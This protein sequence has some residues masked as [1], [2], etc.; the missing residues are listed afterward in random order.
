LV[1]LKK[2]AITTCSFL[3]TTFLLKRFGSLLACL[4]FCSTTLL[5]ANL[6][7]ALGK[8]TIASSIEGANV[9]ATNATDGDHATRWSS[10]FTDAQ[11]IY[12]D[13]GTVQAIDRVR[14]T[15]ETAY[16]KN[17]RLE[18]SD[19]AS[20][21]TTVKTVVDN[22]P[23]NSNN[24]FVNEY[25]RLNATGRYVRIYGTTRATGYGY[26]LFEFEVFNYSNPTMTLASGKPATASNTQDTFTPSRAFDGDSTTRW[27]TTNTTNQWLAV[28]LRGTGTISRV[29]LNWERAWGI[30]YLVQVSDDASTWTTVATVTNNQ[31]YY[32]ELSMPK[33]TRGRYVRLYGQ[34]GGQNAGGFSLWEF[35][36]YGSLTPLASIAPLPVTLTSFSAAG[37]GTGV[38]VRWA[39]ASEQHNAGF[40]VQR[41]ANG[42]DFTS[43]AFVAG[44]GA[45]QAARTYEY[46]DAAPLPTTGYYRLKQLDTDGTVAYS[47]V[48][49][50]Q[51]AAATALSPLS[52]Y[53]NPATDRATLAWESAA[54]SA[55]RWY[56][57]S[58]TGQVV[59]SEALTTQ[60]GPNTLALD[61]QAYPSGR[62][63]LT[64][65]VAG[66]A[67]R[68]ALVQK[69]E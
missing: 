9:A 11:Y 22:Q 58:L 24:L 20:T 62:Y 31:A 51:A 1:I 40:E 30:D 64:L 3:M 65:E 42:V 29:C 5:A 44:A 26:S 59:H 54:A 10:A 36:V 57:T 23:L 21:W 67:L 7:L 14:L 39:T 53:P 60:V 13:L 61:L 17:F 19:N 18:V 50:V 55:G 41:A 16:G 66:Q 38:A 45:S 52:L 43:L 32:N 49:A 56:L 27:S 25:G 33:G 6:N 4:L 8:P 69:A 12:V 34:T 47:A 46:L 15:W 28:D 37:Q 35:K 63:V 48:V 2:K 68:R